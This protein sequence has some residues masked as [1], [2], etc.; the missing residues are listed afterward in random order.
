MNVLSQED[1]EATVLTAYG[2][3]MPALN[4][5]FTGFTVVWLLS[6]GDPKT[7]AHRGP[8]LKPCPRFGKH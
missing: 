8:H 2:N 3:S 6:M 7:A 4:C 1:G 5:Q